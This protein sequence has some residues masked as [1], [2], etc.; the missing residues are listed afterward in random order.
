MAEQAAGD[1]AELRRTLQQSLRLILFLTIPSA[2]GLMILSHPLVAF[3]FQ[4]GAFTESSTDITQG[5]LLFYA[6][7][8]FAHAAIEILSRGFYALSDTRTP[9]TF[10]IVSLVANLALSAAFVRPLEVEGLALAVS[11]ATM[12]EAGL[13]FWTLRRRMEGLDL[14]SLGGS[15][16]RTAV[17]AGVMAGVVASYLFLLHLAGHLDTNRVLDAFLALAGG[18][19]AG[20]LVFLGTARLLRAEEAETLLS[21]LPRPGQP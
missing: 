18:G 8:L 17:S 11:L 10:A 19:L 1:R 12:L 9:V 15:L 21:R 5:V 6:L 7:G 2:V 16:G 4:H 3:L 13:L 14:R 20:G